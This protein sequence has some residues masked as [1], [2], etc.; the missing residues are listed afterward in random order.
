[1]P[2]TAASRYQRVRLTLSLV[3]L[4]VTLAT[5]WVWTFFGMAWGARDA[6]LTLTPSRW[7]QIGLYAMGLSLFLY[8]VT[9]PLHVTQG[10]FLEKAFGLSQQRLRDWFLREA[11]QGILSLLLFLIVV[12][13]GYA[14]IRQVPRFWWLWFGLFWFVMSFGLTKIFPTLIVPLFYRYSRIEDPVLVEKLT[15]FLEKEGCRLEGIWTIDFSKETTKA[16]AAM[17]GLG[18]SR[19]VVLTDT[20]IKQFTPEEIQTVVAHE[21]GHRKYRH[22]VKSLLFNGGINLFGFFLLGKALSRI[23]VPPGYLGLTDLAGLSLF[24]FT[25]TLYGFCLLPLQMDFRGYLS[26]KRTPMRSKPREHGG[27]LFWRCRNWPRETL[28]NSRRIPGL[29]SSFTTTPLSGGGSPLQ[30]NFECKEKAA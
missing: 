17:M 28:R 5:L 16:N 9:F 3:E 22:L 1:M 12:E 14:C 4:F 23:L 26:G 25:F 6:V 18:K 20:L 15:H 27:I 13:I 24:L 21:W 8:L 2:E 19:R 10:Y 29:N 11:K 30:K 7:I